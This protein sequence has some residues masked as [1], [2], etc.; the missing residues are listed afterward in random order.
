MQ[1]GVFAMPY[2]PSW[3]H[4]FFGWVEDLPIP[5]W[6]FYLLFL[7]VG[8]TLQHIFAWGRGLLSVGQF[9]GY[10]ALTWSW[11]VAQLYY[12]QLNTEIAIR[13]LEEIYPLL[14]LD[15]D[16]FE[17]FS[18]RFV[19]IPATLALI[20]QILGFLAGLGFA[21]AIRPFSPELNY[22]V[23]A[24]TFISWGFT[25]AMAFVSFYWI[26]RQLVLIKRIITQIS[27]VDIYHLHPIYGL[28]RLTASMGAAIVVIALLN[29]VTHAPQHLQSVFAV[30]F[31]LAFL[32]L[33]LAV[34]VLPLM[35]INRL[36]REEKLRLLKI[37]S[38]QIEETFIKLREDVA[39]DRFDRLPSLQIAIGVL[40][41]ERT[42]LESVSTWPWA[43]STFRGF[44]AVLSSPIVVWLVQW[45]LERLAVL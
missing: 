38:I 13:S 7:L 39:S 2:K 20:L 42:L 43:A 12:G 31:Y 19:T 16:E 32:L 35:E 37:V 45:V 17:L 5:N 34:F 22:A 4:R 25:L 29:Y 28:S 14:D 40:I 8:G 6:L 21:A 9:N 41:Q 27:R 11:L 36:L 15:H 1:D 23:P 3:I 24:F 10:L 26:I 44:I 33:G 30:G 18:Y